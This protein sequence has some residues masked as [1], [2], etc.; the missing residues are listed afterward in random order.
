MGKLPTKKFLFSLLVAASGR[1]DAINFRVPLVLGTL[2]A[3]ATLFFK[4]NQQLKSGALGN[5][6]TA[7]VRETA[8]NT[9]AT[10]L[11]PRIQK[12]SRDVVERFL[13]SAP[14]AVDLRWDHC[15]K[16]AQKR[17]YE[18]ISAKL[19]ALKETK[20]LLIAGALACGGALLRRPKLVAWG[21]L[22][23]A[24]L[25]SAALLAAHKPEIYRA[26]VEKVVASKTEKVTNII[27]D[28]YATSTLG[29]YIFKEQEAT[30]T[31]G[32]TNEPKKEP[33]VQQEKEAHILEREIMAIIADEYNKALL[34]YDPNGAVALLLSK[35]FSKDVIS[36][37]RAKL[38]GYLKVQ[39]S[40]A[41]PP[42]PI[43]PEVTGDLDSLIWDAYSSSTPQIPPQLEQKK[44]I[45]PP[46]PQTLTD[47]FNQLRLG[48]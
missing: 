45:P 2:G 20:P 3:S 10:R 27:C 21:A 33:V 29:P 16:A 17:M 23:L 19:L 44:P 28:T 42:K 5:T 35:K 4:T 37:L 25:S 11:N 48:T 1:V 30:K 12:Y 26:T 15:I 7:T 24:N 9:L 32:P 14:A 31:A 13:P 34:D 18:R 22:A 46:L 43:L 6:I 8:V 47:Q 41:P 38:T 36:V 39:Q 40:E